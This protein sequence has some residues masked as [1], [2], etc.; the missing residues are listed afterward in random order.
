MRFTTLVCYGTLLGLCAA[1]ASERT[2]TEPPSYQELKQD[3]LASERNEYIRDTK[4]RLSEVDRDMQHVK[5]KLDHESKFVDEEQ[6]ASWKQDLFEL[7]QERSTL[8][9][10]LEH[11]REA[12]PAEWEEMRGT[13]GTATDSLQASARKLRAEVSDAL[14]LDDQASASAASRPAADSGLCRVEVAGVEADV[15]RAGNRVTVTL[16]ADD[17]G[18][19]AE[20]QRRASALAQSTQSY[21]VGRQDPAKGSDAK[22]TS[23]NAD[24]PDVTTTT[25]DQASDP[26]KD[27]AAPTAEAARVAV[28]VVAEK[29]ATGAKLTFVPKTGEVEPLRARLELEAEN[30]EEG[31]CQ[32]TQVSLNTPTK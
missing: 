26:A 27:A 14:D 5:A 22:P 15:E 10:Q 18:N 31:R 29:M 2:A 3:E 11:A 21:E 1:C 19:V 28:N 25:T 4:Q 17:E 32:A 23:A 8:E 9:A 24:K 13:L 20:L 6:R 7:Q 16:T 12:S 30:L